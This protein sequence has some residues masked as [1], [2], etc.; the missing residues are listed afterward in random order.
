MKFLSPLN[1]LS[2][3]LRFYEA[4]DCHELLNAA[5]RIGNLEAKPIP[6]GLVTLGVKMHLRGALNTMAVQCNRDWVWP[7]WIERQFNP[8]DK[9]FIPRSHALSHMNLTHRNWT[10]LGAL[11]NSH[12]CVVD[13]RGLITPWYDGWSLDF[14][15]SDPDR[16]Y[17]PARAE[18]F[19]Q[20]I[21]PRFPQ[22]KNHFQAGELRAQSRVFVV[23]IDGSS[24]VVERVRL[25]NSGAKPRDF[26][27]YFSIRPYNPEG[28]SLI[29]HLEFLE[30]RIWQ[31]ND[32]SAVVLTPVPQ[33][34][35]CSDMKH[36]DVSL[37]LDQK[38]TRRQVTCEVGMATGLAE[39]MGSLGPSERTDY[40][41]LI[42]LDP[43]KT[44][45]SRLLRPFD[46]ETVRR[47]FKRAWE[48]KLSEG[49]KLRFPDKKLTH[50]FDVNRAHL[51]MFD[52]GLTM[53]PGALTYNKCWLRD[54]A[55]MIHALDKLGFHH[56]AEQKVLYF[57]RQQKRNGYFA[58]QEGEWDANGLAIWTIVQHYRLTGNRELLRQLYS[59]VIKGANWI[60]QN[61]HKAR[62]RT[63]LHAGLLPAG[64]SAEHLGPS[65]YYYWDNFWGLAGLRDAAFAAGILEKREDAERLEH[66]ASDYRKSI[67][68]SLT[69][70]DSRT[71]FPFL[72]ATPY[73]RID[74][75]AIGSLCAVY[76]LGLFEA[77][78]P[79]VLNTVRLLEERFLIGDG[80]FQNHVHSGVNCYLS[81][82]LGQCY[83]ANGNPRAW[84]VV[85]YLLRH[86]S[87]TFTWPEAFHPI[88]LGGCMGEGHH[89]WAA[90]E[91]ALL[92]RNLMFYEKGNNLVVTPL[93]QD[94]D[95]RPGNALTVSDAPSYFGRIGIAV[96][97]GK[98][99]V[100]L[101]IA[102]DYRLAEPAAI[103][104]RLPFEPLSVFID[105]K[106][107]PSSGHDLV[108]SPKAGRVVARR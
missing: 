58:F 100:V 10:I 36:G 14:W 15:V 2:Q 70:S 67:E 101:E 95:L 25:V 32:L 91:W 39:Y 7:Y 94:A 42:P 40:L 59:S 107:H 19:K 16:L 62:Q 80:F 73:R 38:Q 43:Q 53:T 37:Y 50:S 33:R 12:R 27:F 85:K 26:K 44:D 86:A 22:L 99:E 20:R 61:R 47:T 90:A 66:F 18:K 103:H 82:Q 45:L 8:N 24:Y 52:R 28:I 57:P 102:N 51:H 79:R 64:L 96:Y 106:L 69:R 87:S 60:E 71:G 31:V 72:P 97:A 74:S 83:L 89:G 63:S 84:Q 55:F 34:I 35:F 21:H 29:R 108:V 30:N 76:P 3:A 5:T 1:L 49:A 46:Y 93:L 105:D 17:T 77:S 75:G 54:S 65:D 9:S 104:W 81:A 6:R 88:T 68:R 13:P 11:G 4:E 41:A 23:E 98:K 48:K 56:Q 92:L 78:D